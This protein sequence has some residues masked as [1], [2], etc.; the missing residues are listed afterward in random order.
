MIAM[1]D[2]GR[3]PEVRGQRSEVRGQ[4]SE[5]RI[6]NAA[7]GGSEGQCQRPT[8]SGFGQR[9]F[10][11]SP[12]ATLRLLA[13][14]VELSSLIIAEFLTQSLQDTRFGHSN[15]AGLHLQLRADFAGRASLDHDLP[16]RL[17]RS[18]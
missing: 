18:L 14:R 8:G 17:P 5:V 16:E 9:P 1:R 11:N 13:V 10:Q 3:A 4:R 15:V 2:M 6:Q 12:L 7:V